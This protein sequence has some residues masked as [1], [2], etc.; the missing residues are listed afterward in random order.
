MTAPDVVA[1][2]FVAQLQSLCYEQAALRGTIECGNRKQLTADIEH[3]A[4]GCSATVLW[5]RYI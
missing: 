1:R 3:S 2:R 4:N 5:Q